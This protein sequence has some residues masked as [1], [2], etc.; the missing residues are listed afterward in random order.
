VFARGE[1]HAKGSDT[2]L[3]ALPVQVRDLAA[4]AAP[5]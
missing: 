4:V 5:R 2:G 3:T 1:L